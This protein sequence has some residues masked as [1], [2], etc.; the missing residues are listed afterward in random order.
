M[1]RRS[2][3]GNWQGQFTYGPNYGERLRGT[4]AAFALEITV[5][6]KGQFAGTC[7]ES[8]KPGVGRVMGRVEGKIEDGEIEFV[9]T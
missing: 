9:K 3:S 4:S 6:R 2:F 1:G 5:D 8:E 7:L